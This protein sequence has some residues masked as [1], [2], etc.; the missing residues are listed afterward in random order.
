M[1]FANRAKLYIVARLLIGW[2][3][4]KLLETLETEL[5]FEKVRGE[6]HSPKG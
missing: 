3:I 2:S 5:T 6:E 4:G 1:Y